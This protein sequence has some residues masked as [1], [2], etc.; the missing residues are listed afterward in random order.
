MIELERVELMCKLCYAKGFATAIS[1][2]L[3]A[4]AVYYAIRLRMLCG[5]ME[6]KLE[7]MER[8]LAGH[9]EKL[10]KEGEEKDEQ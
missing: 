1:A 4:A 8:R 6:E 7:K 3:V 5:D 9:E 2:V 10:R